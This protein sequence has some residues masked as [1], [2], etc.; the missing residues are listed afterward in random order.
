[1]RVVE[2][3][4]SAQQFA[5]PRPVRALFRSPTMGFLWLFVR[6]YI[7]W[8]W[9]TAGW[10]KTFGGESVGWTRDG[11]AGDKF[12]H[13]GDKIMAFWQ[14][15]V[16]P[17]REGVRPQVGYEWYRD[18]LQFMIDHRWNGW[19]AYVIAYGELLIGL[20]LIIGAFTGLTAVAGATMTFNY[21]LAG[22][23]SINPVMFLGSILLVAAWKNAGYVGLDRWL[24]PALG[25]P[26]QPGRLFRHAPDRR[27]HPR[28]MPAVPR[29]RRFIPQPHHPFVPLP[30]HRRM[31]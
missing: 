16:E 5:D 14:R 12:L 28:R 21:M 13:G 4:M 19:F 26:W 6:L 24:L 31:V 22:S 25:V 29:G 3:H 17:P 1:M 9:L 7:G 30:R 10:Q 8:Q 15:A 23:A 27:V 18:F 2:S 11:S 20:A